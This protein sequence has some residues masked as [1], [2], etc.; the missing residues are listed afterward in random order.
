MTKHLKL[1]G[2]ELMIIIGTIDGYEL[3]III[4][5]IEFYFFTQYD[6]KKKNTIK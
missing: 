3:M 1:Y 2:H 5:T 4:G 6:K